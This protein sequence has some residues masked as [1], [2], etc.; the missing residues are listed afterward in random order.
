MQSHKGAG[1]MT[2]SAAEKN[3]ASRRIA[4]IVAEHMH[5]EGPL[6]PVLHA[7]QDAVGCI[8]GDAVA[9]IAKAMNLSRAEVHGVVSFYHL[10]RD[11]PP[12]KQ[13]LY[14]CRAE[15]CQSMG[16]NR[17]AEHARATLGI[18]FHETTPDGRFSLEPI[19]CLGNCACA[20]AVMLDD[21]LH[22]RVSATRLNEI[23]GK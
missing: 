23:V 17:L 12:G 21:T 18:D 22:G 1:V 8:D 14:V 5:L 2:T 9:T 7:V 13:T 6:L 20:P 19:Y 4:R 16:G 3:E 15:A 10:F 11:T